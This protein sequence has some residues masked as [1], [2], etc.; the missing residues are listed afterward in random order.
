[1][2]IFWTKLIMGIIAEVGIILSGYLGLST[3]AI[4]GLI[5]LGGIAIGGQAVIDGIIAWVTG[6]P[7]PLDK[8]PRNENPPTQS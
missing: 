8:G 1:M 7:F 3:V 5:G 6:R 4:Y 2:G